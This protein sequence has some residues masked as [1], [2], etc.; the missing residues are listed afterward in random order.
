LFRKAWIKVVQR[1]FRA[2][3]IADRTVRT[4]RLELYSQERQDK[5]T[6]LDQDI[7]H[8][9]TMFA[10][11]YEWTENTNNCVL[12]EKALGRVGRIEQMEQNRQD[13]TDHTKLSEHNSQDQ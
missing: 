8:W 6:K 13:T 4:S 12:L 5:Y 11:W 1:I 3:Q 2:V 10:A 9:S 7:E